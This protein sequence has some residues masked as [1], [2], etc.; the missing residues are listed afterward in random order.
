MKKILLSGIFL[1]AFIMAKAQQPAFKWAKN[2]GG[3]SFDYGYSIATDVGGNVYTT[4]YFNDIVDFDPGPGEFNSTSSGLKDIYISKLDSS[5]NFVWVK[6]FGGSA[7][8]IGRCIKV[9]ATGDI[10][11][12][13]YFGATVDF[14]PGGGAFNMTSA[15][16]SDIFILKMD[17][18]GNFVWARQFGG[19][20]DDLGFSIT[21]DLSGNI[22]ATGDFSGTADFN[23]GTGIFNLK[24]AGLQDVFIA[25]LDTSGNFVWAKNSGGL[26][27]DHGNAIE[28]DGAGNSYSIGY[29][30]D[31]AD[32]N[33]GTGVDNLVHTNSQGVFISKLDASGNYIWAK[34]FGGVNFNDGFSIALSGSGN[35]YTTGYFQDTADFDPG[36]GIANLISTGDQDIFILK[37]D[38]SGNFVWA[39]NV[40]S[41]SVDIGFFLD[42]DEDENS[43]ITGIIQGI[44][45]FDPGV[46]MYK[47]KLTGNRNLFILKL[48]VSGNFVWAKTLEISSGIAE[49]YALALDKAENLY[50]TGHFTGTADFDTDSGIFNLNAIGL[51]DIFIYKMN[52]NASPTS[53]IKDNPFTNT[54]TIY[55]NPTNGLFNIL[56]SNPTDKI[57]IEVYNT[58]GALIYKH[59]SSYKNY[60]IDLS[61]HTNG[62]YIVKVMKDNN[63]IATQKII[64]Q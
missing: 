38:T 26:N 22:Y 37:L 17:A 7:I 49:G 16:G 59:A 21:M 57:L 2:M 61:N 12:T 31:T 6:T 11:I 19:N 28:V 36:A 56:L 55:P 24:S 48:N 10:Y 8:D 40:G 45:D 13:G 51:D 43:Y 54:V 53:D 64:K 46:G 63:I 34:N 60:T 18:S 33:P 27:D 62:L 39:K 5:G 58:L 41:K 1:L 14:N 29:F 9:D 4:G 47:L 3:N 25:K 35:I 32:F 52:K 30:Q 42:I 20:K 44:T 23:P 15:G 50:C